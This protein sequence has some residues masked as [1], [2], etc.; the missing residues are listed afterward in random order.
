LFI[1]IGK[2]IKKSNCLPEL[3]K[4][5]EVLLMPIRKL[6]EKEVESLLGKYIKF[7]EINEKE[8]YA[9]CFEGVLKKNKD[10]YWE[11][12]ENEMKKSKY[13]LIDP[14]I[15]PID[16]FDNLDGVFDL[17]VLPGKE[18]YVNKINCWKCK[19]QFFEAY[20]YCPHCG[21]PNR[22]YKEE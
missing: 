19:K 7:F 5:D 17:Q 2:A 15:G 10:E 8:S 3:K 18:R 20:K 6:N 11:E 9:L 12:E 16:A 4:G 14:E 13:T 22:L 1:E 21:K